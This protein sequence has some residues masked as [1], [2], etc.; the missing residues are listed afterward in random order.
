MTI[1]MKQSKPLI[2]LALL[3]FVLTYPGEAQDTVKHARHSTEQNS[4]RMKSEERLKPSVTLPEIHIVTHNVP[5]EKLHVQTPTQVIATTELVQLGNT[6]LSDAAR[7][8]VGVTLK[9]YGGVGGIKTVSS[10]GLGSQFTTLTID[11][12]AVNDCQNGQVDLGRYMLG[13]S[14]YISFANGQSD[15][16]L[17]SAR[18]LAA[19]SVLNMETR[20][21]EFGQHP[22]NLSLGMEAGSF[23]YLMPSLSYEQRLGRKLSFSFWGNY[24]QSRGDYPFT[25]Y[26]THT[27]TDSSSREYRQNSHMRMGTADLNLFYRIDSRQ[28]LHLKAHYMKGFHALPGPVIYYTQHGSEH[29]EEDLFFTQARYRRT[30]RHW[31]LQLLGKYQRTTDIYEDTSVNNEAHLLHNEYHQQEGYFSQALRYH[32][33]EK[34]EGHEPLS[35]SLS[36]DESL[37]QLQ[38]NLSHDNNVQRLSLLGVLAAE[39]LPSHVGLLR[40]LRLNANLLGTFIRDQQSG[41]ASSP[42]AKLSPYAG[43]SYRMGSFTL[44]YFF[45]ETYRVPNFNELYY[46]TVGRPLYPERAHQH[47]V[48]ASFKSKV[49]ELDDDHIANASATLDLYVNHVD[50]KI[51][52]IP[53]QNMYLWSM[54]N[55]GKVEVLGID[56]TANASL[57]GKFDL[58]GIRRY[59]LI[60][61]VGYS[62]QYAVDRTTPGGKSYGH[63]I[64][65]TPRHS[66]NLSLTATTPWVD[67]G[68]SVMLVGERY[69]LYQNT[70]ANLVQGYVDQGI[71]L[72]RTFDLWHGTLKAKAQV[73]NLFD[74]QYEVVRGYPMMGRNYRIGITWSF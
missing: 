44:R 51:I 24:L 74:V 56:V 54:T 10:R 31:D 59:D 60:L 48:G 38:S 30:G 40:G 1:R 3:L 50:D 45:K 29:S 35:V 57:S 15:N 6:L 55:M 13:N 63:Q 34:Q 58:N 12:V 5:P 4:S 2:I 17:Q 32:A 47:N 37:S 69:R 73:L 72:T 16:L 18:S 14:N 49:M 52:A 71:T 64:P 8:L 39:Y 21:P 43:L 65:Y 53:I 46:Y 27:H 28:I 68:Y 67:L 42:Y 41:I 23:G 70:A 19:G 33:G 11:G 62:Y 36:L 9:D 61:D 66:G 7:R 20:E 22:Y 25:L 26:Y